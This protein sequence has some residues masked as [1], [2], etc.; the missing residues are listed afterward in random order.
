MNERMHVDRRRYRIGERER[1]EKS[2]QQHNSY[3]H[4]IET[5]RERQAERRSS[6]TFSVEKKRAGE[7]RLAI[8]LDRSLRTLR[9]QTGA[10]L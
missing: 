8:I 10:F 9:W 4:R 1:R 7:Q 6:F 5:S 3:A 2:E